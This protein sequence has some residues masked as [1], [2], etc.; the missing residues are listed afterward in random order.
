MFTRFRP[1]RLSRSVRFAAGLLLVGVFAFAGAHAFAQTNALQSASLQQ[2]AAA[3]KLPTTPLPVIIARLIRAVLGVI[4]IVLVILVVWAGY[5]YMTAGGD[6]QKAV[7]AKNIIK[8]AAIGLVIALSAFTITQFILSRLES[9]LGLSGAI[10]QSSAARYQE[11]LAAA[12]NGKVIQDH[13]PER[14]ALDI[15]RNT[16]IMVT[17]VD[18]I[19][20]SSVIQNYGSNPS[21]T[22]LNAD[23][24][25]IYATAAGQTTALGS[26][27]VSV[28]MS[29]DH[30]I[31][32]FKP[33]QLLGN[34][35]ADTNYTV[36]L[37]PGIE[38]D[39]Q[40]KIFGSGS[41]GYAWTFTVTTTVDLTPP[42]VVSVVPAAASE[43]ARNVT[44]EIT[45]NKAMDPMTASGFYAAGDAGKQFTD[46]TVA[47]GAGAGTPVNG[48]FAISNGYRTVDF[49]A[50]DACAQDA[51]QDVIYCL[52]ASQ[53]IRV[54]ARAASVCAAKDAACA[55]QNP[56]SPPQAVL[57]NGAYDGLADAAGNSLD[58]GE[59]AGAGD[60]VADGPDKDSYVWS[61]T[62]DN[63]IDNRSP[64]LTS[65]A[66]SIL[67][68][69]TAP[70]APVQLAFSMPMKT[71]TLV[72]S[73]VSLWPDP[74]YATW[75][76]ARSAGYGA[77]GKPVAAGGNVDHT[78][79]T[80]EHPPFIPWDA[81]AKNAASQDY[82]PVVTKDV[83]G[84]NQFCYFPALG[85]GYDSATG[86][87]TGTCA[88]SPSAPYCCNGQPQ[89]SACHAPKSN[90]DLPDTSS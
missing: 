64:S 71:D 73:N 45:F 34:D 53:A 66:P 3:S 59:N 26:A 50:D 69:M 62:T 72:D 79:V 84:I 65:L 89:A 24:V 14:D 13:Y 39:K 48:A 46:I 33:R 77:D 1:A 23:D 12:L 58:A 20:P 80:L 22:D 18:P 55:A 11:P 78:E 4:G 51:C 41:P 10:S 44:V 54:T 2:F 28:G 38:N 57:V 43:Q 86:A 90:T 42:H 87:T 29:A 25:K 70:D 7:R 83:R 36:A 60:G 9:A 74:Y 31:F 27:A 88:V 15:P 63:A 17:F 8:N 47:A 35:A 19:Y 30:R 82:Y 75:F 85:P 16:M 81:T 6:P 76:L 56:S 67:H 61:F 5:L 40:T 32:T 49:T 52:P 68:P 21:S 37:L